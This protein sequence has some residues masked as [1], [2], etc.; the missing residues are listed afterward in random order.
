MLLYYAT[1]ALGPLGLQLLHLLMRAKLIS[2]DQQRIK[3]VQSRTVI[4][5]EWVTSL[6]EWHW[7]PNI[8]PKN[9]QSAISG[10]LSHFMLPTSLS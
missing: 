1:Y 5:L 9:L 8:Q 4:L 3:S 10:C 2:L 6:N 7:Q